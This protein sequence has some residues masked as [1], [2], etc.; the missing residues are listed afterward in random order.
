MMNRNENARQP[1]LN[2]QVIE[3]NWHRGKHAFADGN[4]VNGTGV[5]DFFRDNADTLLGGTFKIGEA[6]IT[7]NAARDIARAQNS[8]NTGIGSGINTVANDTYVPPPPIPQKSNAGI[9]IVV[10]LAAVGI[11]VGVYMYRKHAKG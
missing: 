9:Y 4:Y 2:V 10:A 8:P 11:G 3:G 1:E 7:A 6:W 5:G